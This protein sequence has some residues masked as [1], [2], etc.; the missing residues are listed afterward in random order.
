M[1]ILDGLSS[2]PQLAAYSTDALSTIKTDALSKLQDLAPLAKDPNSHYVLAEDSSRFVRFGAFSIVRGPQGSIPHAY[3]LQ[4]PTTRDNAMR[5]FRASQ[6]SKPILLEGSPGV[7]KT[8]LI[9]ALANLCGFHLCRINLSDQTDLADLFGSD[10]PVE[11]GRPGEFAWKDAEFLR[12]LQEGHWVLL[13]EMNLA[14]QAVLEGLNAVLDHRGTVYVPELGRSFTRHPSFRI[15]AAQN[16]IHQGGGRKGLPKSFINRFTKVYI[17]PLTPTDLLEIC[18][19]MFPEYPSDWLASMIAFNSRLEEEVSNKKSFARTGSP[20]EFNLRD[21]TR[22]GALLGSSVRPLHPVEHLRNIYLVRFRTIEDRRAARRIFDQHFK[23]SSDHLE[24]SPQPLISPS[25]VQ[26]GHYVTSR[27]N[28]TPAARS[29]CLLQSQ[30]ILAEAIGVSLRQ[31]WLVILTGPADSGKTTLVKTIA[32]LTGNPLHE[33]S[34]NSATDTT[35]ILGSFEQL[36]SVGH[37]T[38]VV[39]RIITL[40][41][42][43]SRSMEGSKMLQPRQYS[44]LKRVA[45]TDSPR[46]P[47]VDVLQVAVSILNELG[48]LDDTW[49]LERANLLAL[50]KDQISPSDATGRFEW[51]DGPLVRAMEQGHWV[52]LDNANLCSPSV[53]DRL[54]SLCEPSGVLTLSERGYVD[55]RVR[56]ICPHPNFRLFMSVNPQHGELSRAMRNRGI[57]VALSPNQCLED[58]RR[59][60]DYLRLP[61]TSGSNLLSTQSCLEF[62]SLRRALSSLATSSRDTYSPSGQRLIEDSASSFILHG[63]ALLL[64]SPAAHAEAKSYGFLSFAV[65][66]SSPA[67]VPYVSRL[68]MAYDPPVRPEHLS[69]IHTVFHA[70]R[71]SPLWGTLEE[72]RRQKEHIWPVSLD[73]LSVQVSA[74]TPFAAFSHFCPIACTENWP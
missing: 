65:A 44:Y 46:G 55:G 1:T 4:A 61:S 17:E 10:L 43:I 23:L 52:L 69:D 33:L 58:S 31:S 72:I 21:V 30:L 36:D 32:D 20:W 64:P 60:Q 26:I 67:Y 28:Y 15:F 70:M 14:P 54:N 71:K 39:Q 18:R 47:S 19:H 41:E 40:I 73:L 34:V 22:W 27:S 57:E 66:S 9:T 63:S 8:S 38:H 13:D 59:L 24:E 37:T 50:I 51:V 2:L 45:T 16:P 11:G 53:L 74:H 29:G 42:R 3:N 5:V 25:S 12:A 35:D 56:T 7:G 62:E 49:A 68:A 48:D 6:V